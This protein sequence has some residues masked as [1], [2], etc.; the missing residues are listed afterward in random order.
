[1]G[2]DEAGRGPVLGPMVYG[3]CLWSTNTSTNPLVKIFVV[4]FITLQRD[5]KELTAE[6]RDILYAKLEEL[7]NEKQLRFETN[8]LSADY[9]SNEMLKDI[10]ASLNN[11]SHDAAMQLI[12]NALDK[13]F[14]VTH[15]Y[16]DAVGPNETYLKK[17]RDRFGNVNHN[18]DFTVE[19]K[20]D[21]NYPVVSAASIAA[22]VT[23]DRLIKEWEDS[24]MSVN[25]VVPDVGSGYPGD[26]RTKAWLRS[27]MDRLFGYPNFVRFSWET[28]KVILKEDAIN[29][30]W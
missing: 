5:S 26:P 21:A 15:V 23:R 10:P 18:L 17:L 7:Q 24:Q 6:R 16:L 19:S 30:D 28:T 14:K 8:V 20:A 9:L 13:G 3:S 29:V 27:N 12:Q 2:I 11:I 25:G 4:L 1:M 22:K